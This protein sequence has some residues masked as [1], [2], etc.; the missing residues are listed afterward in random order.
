LPEKE[1]PSLGTPPSYVTN[2][3]KPHRKSLTR[4][5]YWEPATAIESASLTAAERDYLIE[6]SS[7]MPSYCLTLGAEEDRHDAMVRTLKAMIPIRNELFKVFLAI[8]SEDPERVPQRIGGIMGRLTKFKFYSE[9]VADWEDWKAEA[10]AFFCWDL[11]L[12]AVAVM[13]DLGHFLP[14]ARLLSRQFEVSDPL[15]SMNNASLF[16]VFHCRSDILY[17]HNEKNRSYVNYQGWLC[18]DR[19][20]DENGLSPAALVQ[21]DVLLSIRAMLVQNDFWFPHLL[22]SRKPPEEPALFAAAQDHR[23]FKDLATILDIRDKSELVAAEQSA[24]QNPYSPSQ[25]ARAVLNTSLL[26]SR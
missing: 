11:W 25:S 10:I 4:F 13:I 22:P 16:I 21:A 3:N 20:S 14:L 24:R 12:H 6:L 2:P 9:Q 7:E 8:L 23:A 18:R 5:E 17:V 19:L 26:D 1:K 15:H